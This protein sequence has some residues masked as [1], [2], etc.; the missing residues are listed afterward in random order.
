MT[1]PKPRPLGSTIDVAEGAQVVRPGG[2][3]AEP[4]TITGGV[5]VFD[6]PGVHTIDGTEHEVA[7]EREPEAQPKP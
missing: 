2:S 3:T 1:K 7:A 5:Y 4:R 6:V